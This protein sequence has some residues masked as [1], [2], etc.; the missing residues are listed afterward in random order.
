MEEIDSQV[1]ADNCSGEVVI[2]TENPSIG[3]I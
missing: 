2:A 1:S 3:I